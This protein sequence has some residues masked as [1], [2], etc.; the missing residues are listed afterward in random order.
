MKASTFSF[1]QSRYLIVAFLL[2]PLSFTMFVSCEKEKIIVEVP[3]PPLPVEDCNRPHEI[4]DLVAWF[5]PI[6]SVLFVDPAYLESAITSLS[7]QPL[8]DGSYQLNGVN[9]WGEPHVLRFK[10][11]PMKIPDIYYMATATEQTL[12]ARFGAYFH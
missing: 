5:N 12:G 10:I 4:E 11:A 6:E 8:N 1:C 3:S 9:L 2:L 7:A